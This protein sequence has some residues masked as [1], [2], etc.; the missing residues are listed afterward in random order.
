MAVTDAPSFDVNRLPPALPTTDVASNV[1]LQSCQTFVANA[2]KSMNATDLTPDAVWRDWLSVTG[3]VRTFNK[4]PELLQVWHQHRSQV[5]D[6]TA[7]RAKVSRADKQHA[8][9]NVRITFRRRFSATL[10]GTCSGTVSITAS[11]DGTWKIWMLATMLE[12]LEGHGHPD[13]SPGASSYAKAPQ[14]SYTAV[15]VGAGQ[16]GLSV[17]GRLSALGIDYLL[18]ERQPRLG[19]GWNGRYDS[20]RQHT[21]REYNNLPFGRTFKKDDENLLPASKV[22]EGLENFAH[23][24]NIN[25]VLSTVVT[26]S[27]STSETSMWD[28]ALRRTDGKPPAGPSKLTCKHL[29]LTTG[30]LF[31]TPRASSWR[32]MDRFQGKIMNLTEYKNCRRWKGKHGIVIGSATSAHDVA[33]DMVDSS[34]S[35]VTMVQRSP[36][37]VFPMSWMAQGQAGESPAVLDCQQ[38]LT[39]PQSPLQH[40]NPHWRSRRAGHDIARKGVC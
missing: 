1:N 39:A 17:A 10:R 2:L 11:A 20:V 22:V 19:Y 12:H 40:A 24:H 14:S 36:T 30:S 25:L 35:S 5:L 13:R 26:A 38:P 8:W 16:A 18:I 29:I 21:I 15:I 37:A 27:K 7:L 9:V 3:K 6:L 31:Q 32:H 33:Q 23:D 28:L 34:L 4:A